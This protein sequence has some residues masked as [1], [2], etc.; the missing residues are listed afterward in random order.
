M[1]KYRVLAGQHHEPNTNPK[2][3]ADP[4]DPLAGDFIKYTRGQV[5]ES[6]RPLDRIFVNKFELVKDGSPE[7]T[8]ERR[9]AVNGL[10]TGGSWL[11]ADRQFLE[12]APQSAFDRIVSSATKEGVHNAPRE[13]DLNRDVTKPFVTG[14][15]NTGQNAGAADSGGDVATTEAPKAE[16]VKSRL[17]EDVTD[18]FSSARAK[19]LLVFK[20]K[21]G[22]YHVAGEAQPNKALDESGIEGTDDEVKAEIKNFVENY[23]PTRE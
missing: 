12:T 3:D 15:P 5:V 11:E 7:V 4:S 8:P 20:T 10:I 23:E 17:G 13:D 1:A 9:A 6:D 16:K 2:P 22:K 21:A 19:K 14:G 18:L